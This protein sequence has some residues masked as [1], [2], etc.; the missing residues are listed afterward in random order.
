MAS[1]PL[2]LL[3]LAAGVFLEKAYPN[4]FTCIPEWKRE[5]FGRL[6][7]G[8]SLNDLLPPSAMS[9]GFCEWL[10]SEG[11]AFRLGCD[12]FP[13]LKL[14][15]TNLGCDDQ[16]LWVF[17]VDTHDRMLRLCSETLLQDADAWAVLQSENRRLKEEIEHAW[18]SLGVP[19]QLSILRRQL[20]S[21]SA[22]I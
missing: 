2:E 20:E 6:L 18:E 21:M 16:P 1:Y 13:H 14:R 10:A 11:I 3:S 7:S 12:H 17:I 9:H 15:L 19:T 8:H 22:S 5:R 4:G